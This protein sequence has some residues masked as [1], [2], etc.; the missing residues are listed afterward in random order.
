MAAITGLLIVCPLL[1]IPATAHA[2]AA[3]SG[4]VAAFGMD[5][6]QGT[7]V[8]DASPKRNDGRATTTTWVRG[9]YGAGLSFDGS[10]SVR[11]KDS[12]SLRLSS[13]MTLEAWVNPATTSG[14]RTVLLKEQDR[15]IAYGLFSS[16]DSGVPAAGLRTGSY[17]E[18]RS[19]GFLGEG[20]WTHLASTYD[21]KRLRLYINGVLSR[22]TS[23]TG[24]IRSRGGD[25]TIGGTSVW[26]GGSFEGTL[27]EVRIYNKALT[28]A[29][30][31]TDMNTPINPSRPPSGPSGLEATVHYS[32]VSLDWQPPIFGGDAS[33]YEIHRSATP[34][35][36][37]SDDTW[38]GTTTIPYATRFR[39]EGQPAGVYYY[40]VVALEGGSPVGPPSNEVSATVETPGDPPSAPGTLTAGGRSD[41]ARLTYGPATAAWGISHY[42]L[43]RSTTPGF[44]P[45][46]R[47]R[48]ADINPLVYEDYGLAD[49]VYYYRIIPVDYAGQ[50]GQPSNEA[51]ARVPD[52]P[53]TAPT[54]TVQA[55]AGRA[56][57]SW[58]AASDDDGVTAYRVWRGIELLGTVT[59]RTYVDIGLSAG[60]YSYSVEA[61]DT[62]GQP[63]EMSNVGFAEVTQCPPAACLV[64]AYG[65]DE[66]A[67]TTFADGSGSG[68]DG[69]TTGTT[70]AD[71]RFGKALSFSADTADA[72]VPDSPTVRLDTGMTL[73]AWVYPTEI[74]SEHSIV[75]KGDQQ[76]SSY[77]LSAS[78]IG[79]DE[80]PTG[81][82]V[83]FND[84]RI[85]VSPT[86]LPANAWSH[87]A[88]TFADGT[89][90]IYVNGVEV[91]QEGDLPT[92]FVQETGPLTIGRNEQFGQHY[93]GLI[94][95]IRIYST[96]LTAEQ[97]QADMNTP[98][99]AP[100]R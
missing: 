33:S 17:R 28:A 18:V 44:T 19:T 90:R 42:Q 15:G 66:G 47:T 48:I 88:A 85:I 78:D 69:T 35:F 41:W 46:P 4:L 37:P 6:A 94:D 89:V 77:G 36:T 79:N 31:Q 91:A 21:G 87:V 55:G 8:G 93:K 20:G 27:D 56:E 3:K 54:L 67:G 2:S 24:D 57:L 83:R 82:S 74:T 25:L 22:Q 72:V 59:A 58:T 97:I 70:W 9:K 51:S 62:A 100:P 52:Q 1:T 73:E 26:G 92:S 61:V 38:I 23:V 30:I 14:W 12:A 65:F 84:Y 63:G 40:R 71:G 43:H 50:V 96:P 29:Q 95:E 98:V 10:S 60:R 13:E 80:V 86:A 76:R 64:A 68:N 5:E 81:P 34:G 32:F 45:S 99:G 49:G 7:K 39:D 16:D 53:P 11:V 75:F